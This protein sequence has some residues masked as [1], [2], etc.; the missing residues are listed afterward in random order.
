MSVPVKDNSYPD[1]DQSDLVSGE[2]TLRLIARLP[3]P[4]GFVERVQDGL[5]QAPRPARVLGW[6]LRPSGG[7]MHSSMM[8]GTAAAAIVCVVAGGG[9]R[10]YS[11]VQPPAAAKVVM[12]PSRTEPGTGGF[13]Q[14]G[15]R[16]VPDTLQGPVLTHPI[17]V[18]AEEK[19]TATAPERTAPAAAKAPHKKKPGPR[20]VV[21]PT[22]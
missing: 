22:P 2:D 14:A 6:P 17:A 3:A 10:I 1:H 20:P 8:R 11:R 12:M 5:R 9:W 13:S 15:A 16:R 18:P 19:V 7:W 21:A 4:E